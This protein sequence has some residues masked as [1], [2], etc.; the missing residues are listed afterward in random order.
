SKDTTFRQ[1]VSGA[2][3]DLAVGDTISVRGTTADS[4]MT[5]TRITETAAQANVVRGG[6]PVFSSAGPQDGV[7]IGP[8]GG[9]GP[10]VFQADPGTM[11]L[12]EI[13]KI[14]GDAITLS[15]F[16]GATVTV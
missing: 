8:G 7:A 2:L 3:S 16:D 11:R 9:G 1:S 4:V 6:G 15:A 14:E 13:T 10:R 12:G 5:A